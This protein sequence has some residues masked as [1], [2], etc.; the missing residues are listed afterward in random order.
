MEFDNFPGPER[1]F[2]NSRFTLK[3][4]ILLVFEAKHYNCKLTKQVELVC[5]LKGTPP[6]YR[7]YF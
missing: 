7:F 5:G 3:I 2:M 6:F 4:Q 1:Y